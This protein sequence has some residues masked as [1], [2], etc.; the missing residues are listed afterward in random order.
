LSDGSV[1]SLDGQRPV[2]VAH[3]AK[4]NIYVVLHH[5]NHL[6]IIS[7][8]PVNTDVGYY[9]FTTGSGQVY[10]GTKGC[11]ELATGKWGM[12]AGDGD[13]DGQVNNTDKNDT[14]HPYQ[15][16]SGY[17]GGDFNMNTQVN[18]NDKDIIWDSNAAK[19]TQVPE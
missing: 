9:D 15:G 2:N 17:L 4:N 13:G 19:G 11:K 8:T 6:S 7:S 1:V 18:N 3:E 5:R 10:G 14:W 12:F 16:Q